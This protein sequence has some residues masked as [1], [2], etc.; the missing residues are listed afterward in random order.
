[1]YWIVSSAGSLIAGSSDVMSDGRGGYTL[2]LLQNLCTAMS[3][4]FSQ[5]SALT[6]H[7]LV[8]LNSTAGAVC[9]SV[10][11]FIFERDEV[12]AFPY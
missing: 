2:V 11:G 4:A 7:Q 1:M 10:L 12:L 9:C 6:P 5:E 3:L 8:I